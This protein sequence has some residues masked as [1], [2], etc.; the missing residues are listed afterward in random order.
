VEVVAESYQRA[1]YGRHQ[2]T[3]A[4]RDRLDAVW[5]PLRNRLL[6][7]VLRWK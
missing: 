1:R 7:K 6:K 5:V 2:L 4:E 3:P